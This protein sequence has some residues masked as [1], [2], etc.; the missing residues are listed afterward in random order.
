MIKLNGASTHSP[1]APP[2]VKESFDHPD[3]LFELKHDG[4][5]AV[6]YIQNGEGKLISRNLNNLQFT[7]EYEARF[8]GMMDAEYNARSEAGK[9]KPGETVAYMKARAKFTMD[10]VAEIKTGLSPDG[11]VLFN[12][13]TKSR[14]G[15]IAM[16]KP[17]RDGVENTILQQVTGFAEECGVTPCAL[18]LRF[19]DISLCSL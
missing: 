6:V 18:P 17:P 9:L 2:L 13:I 7:M 4:F 10:V 16:D 5:R 12:A 19:G 15:G 8:P 3:Y 1:D 14:K 11:L